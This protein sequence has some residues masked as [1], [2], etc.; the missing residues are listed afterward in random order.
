MQQPLTR[1]QPEM[2]Y[3]LQIGRALA[4]LAVVFTHSI[5]AAQARFQAMPADWYM[6]FRL[7]YLGVDYFFVLSGFII[8]HSVSKLDMHALADA[9]KYARARFVRIY[10][11]YLPVSLFMALAFTLVPSLSMGVGNQFSWLG[12]LFLLPSDAFPALTVAR[13]LQHEVMFYC[14]FGL[15][16]FYL[17]K[18]L[19]IFL[20]ALP[21]IALLFFELSPSTTIM[22]GSINLEFLF[23]VAA[24]R[25][26]SSGRLFRFRFALVAVG[27]V[28]VGLASAILFKGGATETYRI[29]AGAGFALMALGFVFMERQ[30]DFLRFRFLVFI[31][32][33]SYSIYLV[34]NPVISVMLRFLPATPN[35]VVAFAL[36]A[37]GSA[38]A[39]VVYY[40]VIE[41][42]IIARMK[43][44]KNTARA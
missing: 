43:K 36:F 30:F 7:G 1:T 19:F 38:C 14:L 25:A 10:L 29:L 18:P 20:W 12:S 40:W 3:S 23:G 35:W 33:A 28:A 39:S 21:I 32:A 24:Y 4:V 9:K 41:K 16:Y 42:P 5:M 8:A 13:T 26:Y 6:V 27:L 44:R 31:G 34:H 15:C 37:V 22:V 17:K 11:P 2:L